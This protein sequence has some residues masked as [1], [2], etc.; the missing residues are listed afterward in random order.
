VLL[1]PRK[2]LREL[3]TINAD[4]F[5]EYCYSNENETLRNEFNYDVAR[6]VSKEEVIRLAR[7]HPEIRRAYLNFI[8]KQSPHPYVSFRQACV[9]QGDHP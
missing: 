9:N 4:D 6:H 5:W 2:Y 7:R 3:P 8:E 1:A